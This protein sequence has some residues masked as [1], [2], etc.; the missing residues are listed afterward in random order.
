MSYGMAL[1]AGVSA[2]LWWRRVLAFLFSRW[3]VFVLCLA[4]YAVTLNGTVY[5]AINQ[6][7]WLTYDRFTGEPRWLMEDLRSQTRTEGCVL[8]AEIMAGGEFEIDGSSQPLCIRADLYQSDRERMV[9]PAERCFE[10]RERKSPFTR[11]SSVTGT[12]RVKTR[13]KRG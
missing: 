1:V 8:C 9:V 12:R 3:M 7:P 13:E 11:R 10:V 6:T 4:V 2:V 5:S